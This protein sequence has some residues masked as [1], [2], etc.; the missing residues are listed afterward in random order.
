MVIN[1]IMGVGMLGSHPVS[2]I[3]WMAA[4]AT[5]FAVGLLLGFGLIS[6]QYALSKTKRR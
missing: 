1:T 2:W 4:G 6:Q 5:D 3:F